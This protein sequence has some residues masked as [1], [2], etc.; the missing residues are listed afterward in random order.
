MNTAG[1]DRIQGQRRLTNR[2][3]NTSRQRLTAFLLF[4]TVPKWEQNYYLEP[5]SYLKT[6]SFRFQNTATP[7]LE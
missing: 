4:P 6:V 3:K 2:R 7:K 1:E 5:G